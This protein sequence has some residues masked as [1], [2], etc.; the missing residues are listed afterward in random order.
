MTITVRLA[1]DVER[2]LKIL[3]KAKGASLSDLVRSAIEAKLE[4]EELMADKPS[5]YEAWKSINT[6]WS[7]GETDRSERH[8]E[9]IAH[10]VRKKYLKRTAK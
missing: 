10:E 7:S 2:K 8:S 4:V 1:P 5:P 6:P 9:I 3:A